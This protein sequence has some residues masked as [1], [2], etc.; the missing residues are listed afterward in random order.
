VRAKTFFATA[1]LFFGLASPTYQA[2]MPEKPAPVQQVVEHKQ[3]LAKKQTWQEELCKIG[4]ESTID[5]IERGGIKL[6]NT[7]YEIEN[8]FR[9]DKDK[10]KE[11]L[12][13]EDKHYDSLKSHLLSA[14]SVRCTCEPA[15]TPRYNQDFSILDVRLTCMRTQ[16]PEQRKNLDEPYT[17]ALFTQFLPHGIYMTNTEQH[18]KLK[19]KI[20]AYKLMTN[21]MGNEGEEEGFHTHPGGGPPSIQ[22]EKT[23]IPKKNMLFL[24]QKKETA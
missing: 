7:V 18:N 13:G 20:A 10:F 11:F 8:A 15:F 19:T 23:A 17:W 4:L 3:K 22:D 2:T 1:A 6:G 9:Y 21:I 16:L 24:P 14:W 5:N 12:K